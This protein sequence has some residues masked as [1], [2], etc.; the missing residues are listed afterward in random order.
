MNKRKIIKGDSRGMK[1]F[2]ACRLF[3]LLIPFLLG[4]SEP[5]QQKVMKHEP[6]VDWT[7]VLVAGFGALGA[8]VPAY[9]G[10]KSVKRRRAC[11]REE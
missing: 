10:Y 11:K 5:Q 7:L 6:T 9:Y 1:P 2:R 4:M 3:V 8:C